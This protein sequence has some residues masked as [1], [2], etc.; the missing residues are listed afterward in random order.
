MRKIGLACVL[1]N[2]TFIT[3]A[4]D[5][6][7]QDFTSYNQKVP[8]TQLDIKMVPVKGGSFMMGSEASDKFKKPD[9]L[10]ATKVTVSSFWMGA[11]E[12]THD[13]FDIYFRDENTIVGS[14]AD[15]VTRPTPQ[16]IDLSWGMGKTGGYPVNSMSQDAALMFCRWLYDKTGIFYRLPT[17]AEWEYACRAGSTSIYPFGDNPKDLSK[18]AWY[19]RNSKEKYHKV[20]EKEPNAWGLYDMLGNVSEWTL[21]QYDEK[22]YEKLGANATDPLI[23]P[24]TRYPRSLRGGNYLDDAEALRSA[25]RQH[26]ESS[27]NKR[28]P[29]I[30]RSRWWLTDGMFVGFRIVRPEK[31]P[32]KQEAEAFYNKYLNK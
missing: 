30:P 3:H 21:D 16:Y 22:Y 7:P 5:S 8:G 10:P 12:I 11:Y 13:I 15:V 4:Q 6:T 19:K 26:S 9:E 23:P 14:Q 17:E 1:I 31:Q 29:Q 32:N 24:A 2:L 20:G 18:Y 28:D 25:N 27:W